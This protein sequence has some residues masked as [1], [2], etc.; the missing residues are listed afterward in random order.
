MIVKE[1]GLMGYMS[2]NRS[3]A[4]LSATPNISSKLHKYEN[5]HFA[6]PEL[7]NSESIL[8]SKTVSKLRSWLSSESSRAYK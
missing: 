3:R 8:S 1:L 7:Y 6:L 4:F 5:L 2:K